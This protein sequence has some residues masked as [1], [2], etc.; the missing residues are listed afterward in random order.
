MSDTP[1]DTPS[2]RNAH[3]QV[4]TTEVPH[5]A[6]GS[7]EAALTGAFD[8]FRRS[9]DDLERTML[10]TFSGI[11]APVIVPPVKR[12]VMKPREFAEH[13][14]VN[15]RKVHAWI[16]RGMPHFLVEGRIRI[17]VAEASAWLD[18]H[19]SSPSTPKS[20]AKLDAGEQS[21]NKSRPSR[22]DKPRD[23]RQK[24]ARSKP[25]THRR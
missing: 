17:R 11:A 1:S 13:F 2:D 8:R 24:H 15:V 19:A 7:R 18:S 3:K 5:V 10:A 20:H 23:V 25:K 4:D 22:I 12:G 16:S 9:I 6:R 14:R 21:G